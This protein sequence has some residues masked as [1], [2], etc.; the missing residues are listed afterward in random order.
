M[1]KVVD[2]ST[3]RR[4]RAERDTNMNSTGHDKRKE[5]RRDSRE[6]L[7]VQIVKSSDQDLVGTTIS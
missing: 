3:A 5:L 6:R 1:S 4:R 2:I 7:F